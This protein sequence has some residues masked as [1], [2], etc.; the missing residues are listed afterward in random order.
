MEYERII[1]TVDVPLAMALGVVANI[2]ADVPGDNPMIISGMKNSISKLRAASI[3][4]YGPYATRGVGLKEPAKVPNLSIIGL[5]IEVTTIT[6]GEGMP[7]PHDPLISIAISNGGWYD[8][9]FE[10]KC[11]LIHTFGYCTKTKWEDGRHPAIVKVDNHGVA[12]K[13]AYEILSPDLVSIHNGFNFDLRSIGCKAAF[14]PTI[15]QDVR[16]SHHVRSQVLPQEHDHG[17]GAERTQGHLRGH[18]LDLRWV[19]GT[20][21]EQCMEAATVLKKSIDQSLAGTP[22]EHIGADIKGNYKTILITAR[23][24]YAVVD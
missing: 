14:E 13:T 15:E 12:V 9:Q 19:K 8:K 3:S 7:L 16:G 2:D 5:D 6:R 24:K 4:G 22:F 21:E 1:L 23:K 20:S 10:D 17:H 18:G 11:Y